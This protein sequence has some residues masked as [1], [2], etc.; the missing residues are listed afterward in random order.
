MTPF[1]TLA[2]QRGCVIQTGLEMTET[3]LLSLAG[4]LGVAAA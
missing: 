1:L 2:R 3:Q 4:F